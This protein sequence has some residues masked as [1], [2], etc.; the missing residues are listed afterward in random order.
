ME[1]KF[2]NRPLF[3]F[4]IWASVL[5]SMIIG[6][7]IY[8]SSMAIHHPVDLSRNITPICLTFGMTFFSLVWRGIIL[9]KR[10]PK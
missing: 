4:I 8:F 9:L 3:I 7:T 5:N 1:Y 10:T 6:E 2:E